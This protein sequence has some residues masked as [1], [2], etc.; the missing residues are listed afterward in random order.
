MIRSDLV[1]RISARNPHLHDKGCEAIVD[2]IL[3]RIADALVAG[4]R[5]ELRDFGAFTVTT[6]RSRT[7]WNPKTGMRIPTNPAGNSDLKPAVIPRR[8]RPPFRFE[9]G[10]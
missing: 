3:N 8:S 5:V 6:R 7:G 10:R 1:L 2:A 4:E 9:A